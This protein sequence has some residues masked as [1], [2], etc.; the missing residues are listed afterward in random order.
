M[1]KHINITVHGKVQGVWFRDSTRTEARKLGI[2]GIVRNEPNGSVYIEA[3]E[4]PGKLE[5]FVKWCHSGP[6]LAVVTNVAVREG[7]L[8][9]FSEFVISY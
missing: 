5:E 2:K 7:E 3:E 4:E 9:N 8:K 6:E 1:I